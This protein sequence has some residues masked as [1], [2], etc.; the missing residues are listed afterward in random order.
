[1]DE[2]QEMLGASN[3]LVHSVQVTSVNNSEKF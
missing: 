3:D 1:M 2:I